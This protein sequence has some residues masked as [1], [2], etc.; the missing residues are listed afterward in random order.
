[1]ALVFPT[2]TQAAAQT[3]VNTF[4]PTSSPLVNTENTFVYTY[5]PSK[6]VWTITGGGAGGSG[7]VTSIA[8]GTG[9]TG[10]PITSSGT[11]SLDT[12]YTDGRYLQLSGGTLT[13]V[14]TFAVG[15]TFPNVVTSVTAGTGLSG[16]T[17]TS[18]GTI[19]LANT[20]VAAGS[21]TNASITVDAQ[22]RLTAASSGTTPVT[23][24][25]GTSPIISSGGTTPAISLANTAVTPG[26]YTYS[27]FTVDAQGRL[28]AASSGTAPVTNVTGTSPIVSS[29]GT[30][31]AISLA[32]TAVTPGSYTYS[33]FTVDAQ[34]R[35][36]AA[37]S[38]TSPV[39]SVT[40]TSPVSV[41]AGT[42]PVVSIAAASTTGSGAVQLNDTVTSTSTTLALT[43]NQGKLL[44]DQIN[45][46]SVTTNLTLAGTLNAAT[47]VMDSVTA[48]GTAAG[49]T[50]GNPIPSPAAG[51]IDYFVIVTVPGSYD[52][53]GAG[54][55]YAAT[56]GDWFL[57]D[58]TQWQFLNVGF[59]APNAS[60]TQAGIVELATTAETQAGTDATLAVTPAGAAATYIACST[61]AAKGD[62]ITATGD[63]SPVVLP[64]GSD[65]TYLMADSSAPEGLVWVGN[66][67]VSPF[68]FT[69]KGDILGGTGF[70]TFNA[71]PVGTD[72][73]VL[74][75]CSTA[76]EGLCWVTVTLPT[77]ATPSAFGTLKG[78]ISAIGQN[79]ALGCNAFT[80][81]GGSENV[82]IGATA[83]DAT[84]TGCCNVAIGSATLTNTT[85]GCNNVGVGWSSLSTNVSGCSN[86]A[87]G[88][89][90]LP[91]LTTGCFNIGIG[92]APGNFLST[93][94]N[95]VIIGNGIQ[96]P[97]TDGSCQLVVGWGSSGSETWL[98][99]CSTRAIRPSAGIMDCAGST[100]TAGQV[101]TST[102]SNAICWG[103]SGSPATPTVLGTLLGCTVSGA[104]ANVALGHCAL[105][106]SAGCFRRNIA[107]G[108]CSLLAATATSDGNVAVGHCAMSALTNGSANVAVGVNAATSLTTGGFNVSIG[109]A[110]QF[111]LTSGADN[112]GIG[113]NANGDGTTGSGNVAIG[114]EALWNG[115]NTLDGSNNVAL[116]Y[117]A[118]LAIT[119]GNFNTMLGVQAGANITTGSLNVMIGPAVQASSPTASCQLAIGFSST[120]NWLT[121]ASNLSIKPG[122]GV[123]DCLNSLGTIG[124]Y[125]WAGAN[126]NSIVWA[127][128]SPSDA[129]DKHILGP[130]PTALPLVTKIEPISYRW[131]PRETEESQ[132]EVIYGFSAQ[133]LQEVDTLLVDDSDPEHLRIHDRKLVP[134]LV[135]AIKELSSEVQALKQEVA[136]L[137]G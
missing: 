118:G 9:L 74:M 80:S 121:G 2:P 136:G 102:G 83:L 92:F 53:P 64:V 88:H 22:G 4:S 28:T 114:A 48:G 122:A 39:T 6:G 106:V 18:S 38:G 68:S 40:G 8:S 26:S 103:P 16:G 105:N 97:V 7:T 49:F 17:I 134:L 70:G 87:I 77:A 42:T 135:Q 93:G 11:L 104:N 51:L 127:S 31:P 86:T 12:G 110:S 59:V 29:G 21:Y 131:K 76:F 69:A 133:Q 23:S 32:N 73:Q 66:N 33:S 20:A 99:G 30:T 36:T 71:L 116:G 54:G 112:I 19:A 13:G 94:S 63:D 109:V 81:G 57:C 65:F 46:L 60:T 84:T 113:R 72:G 27:S 100:G 96:L 108:A 129:R 115:S 67:C 1:M 91:S 58:G 128:S 5:L 126:G 47:G 75:A 82:A 3:P 101:L 89:G 130:V 25:T 52:P 120:A 61:F 124:Q 15:Q 98:T 45:A 35:L 123:C 37:S 62:L 107:I 43:A 132:D 79:T 50:V 95:N 85:T 137:K 111:S 56:Q 10:G 90:S 24:V 125:L 34:G 117:R 55:P 119:S 41:T 14:V 44:Q 78:C